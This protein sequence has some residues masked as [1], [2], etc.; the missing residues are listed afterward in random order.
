VRRLAPIELAIGASLLGT[1]VAVAVP[2]FS[3]EL[4]ASRFV[5]PTD[6]LARLGAA[7]VA[8][9]ELRAADA[10]AFPE[11]APLTPAAPP[12][13]TKAVD[14]AGTWD[15]PTWT[16]L[17][18]RPSPEGVPHAFA[19]AFDR[20][21]TGDAFVARARGDL[22]GDGVLSTFEIRGQAPHGDGER[23]VV[24]PGMYVEGELE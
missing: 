22:D 3:R 6:G 14:P 5:E 15:T 4:S 23:P 17:A 20:T 7:A 24:L 8:F 19:F 9:A 12:R 1:V 18:F 13:G 21:A 11:S 2:A 10:P 16:A